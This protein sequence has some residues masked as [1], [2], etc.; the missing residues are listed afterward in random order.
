MDID[1]Q[2]IRIDRQDSFSISDAATRVPALYDGKK[3]Y[4]R[5]IKK[6]RKKVDQKQQM[7]YAHDRYSLLV[8]FQALDAAGK[9]G[10]IRAVFSGVNPHGVQIT[11]FKRPSDAELDHLRCSLRS[12]GPVGKV[13]HRRARR[14][15]RQI[16]HRK[17][18]FPS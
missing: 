14:A 3:D 13:L 2:R 18:D 8:I 7:M 1:W 9:D 16:L 6:L 17:C 4:S 15:T 10:T 11:S 5:K 12:V